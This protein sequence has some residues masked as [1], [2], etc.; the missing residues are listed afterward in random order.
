MSAA[1]AVVD[2]AAVY[3]AIGT[4]VALGFV[5]LGLSRVI[6]ASATLGAR[7]LILPGAALL[8]PVVI[9]RWLRP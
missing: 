9:M 8:W 7:L 4:V 3:A 2:G 5:T 6:H 1:A